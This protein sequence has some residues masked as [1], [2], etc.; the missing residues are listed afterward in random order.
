MENQI[1]IRDRWLGAMCYLSILVLFPLFSKPKSVFLARHSRQGFAL[2][3]FEVVGVCFIWVIDTTLG[4]LPLLGFL[5]VIALRL[6]FF[7]FVLATSVMGFTKA[8][9]GEDWRVPYLDDLADKIPV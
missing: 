2:L 5:V 9:F 6:V 4:R 7:L 3:F 8:I 1:P